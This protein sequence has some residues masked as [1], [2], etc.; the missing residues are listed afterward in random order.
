MEEAHNLYL[1]HEALEDEKNKYYKEANMESV[2]L[3]CSNK[4]NETKRIR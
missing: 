1:K 4:E 2:V 3:V